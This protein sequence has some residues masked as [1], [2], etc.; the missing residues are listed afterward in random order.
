MEDDKTNEIKDIT[1]NNK[2]EKKEEETFDSKMDT[3]LYQL[4]EIKL[5][6]EK[7]KS[8]A[9]VL[10]ISMTERF[11]YVSKVARDLRDKGK[12]V[13]IYFENKKIKAQFKYADKLQIPYTIVIGDDEVNSNTYTIKNMETGDQ[14][15]IN[16]N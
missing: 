3:F 6:E 11:D 2:G 4:N 1:T 15:Q 8:I 10:I 14:Q 5:I 16:I 13:Q 12:N 9:D 7:K